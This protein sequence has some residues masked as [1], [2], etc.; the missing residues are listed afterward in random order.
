MQHWVDLQQYLTANLPNLS[1][2]KLHLL[3]VNG[4][5]THSALSY[6][7][8][9]LLLD[10]RADPLLP[11]V[12]VNRWLQ[13]KHR[14][15]PQLPKIKFSSEVIDKNTFDL[16]IDIPMTDKLVDNG[17]AYHLCPPTYWDDT[18]GDFVQAGL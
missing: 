11:L 6:T 2:D 16:E 17:T 9:I 18:A 1:A 13:A 5:M 10:Y 14:D 3:V 7:I 15:E 12:L 4:D 8:R